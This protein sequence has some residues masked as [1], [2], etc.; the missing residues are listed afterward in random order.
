MKRKSAPIKE[1]PFLL[2]ET[3]GERN[4]DR[5]RALQAADQY[6]G[7]SL[8]AEGYSVERQEYKMEGSVVRNL[9]A[10]IPGTARAGE[11]VIVGAH[12]DTVFECPGAMTTPAGRRRF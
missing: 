12:S 6:V 2:A 8:K 3:I 5:F 7:D 11:I 9:I 10:E 4:L 1:A